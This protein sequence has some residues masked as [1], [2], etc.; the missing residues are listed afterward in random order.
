MSYVRIEL[1]AIKDTREFRTTAMAALISP[2]PD[3]T[4]GL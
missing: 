3:V 1:D 2:I 4:A